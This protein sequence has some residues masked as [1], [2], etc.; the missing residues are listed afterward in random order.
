MARIGLTGMGAHAFRALAAEKLLEDGAS[1]SEASALVGE[2]E[3]P[4]S[5][6]Y[7]SADYRLHLARVHAARALAAAISWAS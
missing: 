3:T 4:N 7:A 2:G 1:V 6:L 5:D